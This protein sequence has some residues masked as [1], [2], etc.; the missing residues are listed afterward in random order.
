[1]RVLVHLGQIKLSNVEYRNSVLYGDYDSYLRNLKN[2][3][4]RG[5]IIITSPDAYD[6]K[7]KKNTDMVP[8]RVL[9][10][11]NII[12]DHIQPGATWQEGFK[13]SGAAKL[14]RLLEKKKVRKE[15][16]IGLCGEQ[17]WYMDRIIINNMAS[18]PRLLLG[19]VARYYN[20]LFEAGYKP[21][22]IRNLCYPTKNP[23]GF[24]GT[25]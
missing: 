21:K 12:V 1:M 20:T 11:S 9:D 4:S 17:L 5:N 18:P 16:E 6:P 22:I 15:E 24:V 25:F 8:F 10:D 3:S 2:N 14:L 13:Y 19:D 7:C 23:P